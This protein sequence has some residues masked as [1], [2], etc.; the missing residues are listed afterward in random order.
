MT[1]AH[2]GGKILAAVADGIG[3]ITINQPEKRNAM[4]VDMWD[5]MGEVLDSF[6]ADAAVRV[7]VM[8]GAGDK[9]FISGADISQFARMRSNAEAQRAY[10]ERVKVGAGKLIAFPKPLIARIRGF[11]LGGGLAVAMRADIRIA[12]DD[13]QFGIPAAKL[14]IA[15]GLEATSRLVALVGPAH[16][17]E[18]LMTGERMPAAEALR[19]G[20]VNRLHPVAELDA[21]VAKLAATIASNA[22]LSV[23][24]AK[25]M[26]DQATRDP[27]QRD[28]AAIDSVIAACFDSADYAEGRAAFM[29]KRKPV[30]TGR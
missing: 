18:I 23:R 27:D 17:R 12:S 2:A 14:G 8:T 5:A 4:S 11:C 9:A 25:V 19:I 28:S 15:Y 6:A 16:A 26:V 3:T 22:P 10:D 24:A 7:C 21:A 20:L 29:E 30:F 13:S 1:T